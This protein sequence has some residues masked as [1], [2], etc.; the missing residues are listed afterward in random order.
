MSGTA[1][2]PSSPPTARIDRKSRLQMVWLIPIVAVGIALFL[3]YR[4]Y[5]SRGPTILLTFTTAD[6]LQAGQTKVKHKA[7][8]LGTV[9]GIR[10]S[11]DMSHVEVSVEMQHAAD[12]LLTERARFWVV[13]PRL[14]VG[15]VSG[16]DTLLSGAY[17]SIDP[18]EGGG[19]RQIRFTGLEEPPA[20][21]SDEPGTTYV[22]NTARIGSLSSGSPVFF[23]DI[24]VGEVLGYDL[25]PN[26]D[27]VAIKVFVRAPYN[28]FV[29]SA[30]RFWN[31][32]G[33][34]VDLGTQGVRVQME[35]LLAVIAGGVAFDTPGLHADDKPI[36]ANT[37]FPLFR[38]QT[39]A[40]ESGYSVNARLMARFEGSVR[41]LAPGA[42]VEMFGIRVG[43][44]SSVRLEAD[45]AK[46][47]LFVE[48][49]F[50]IQ[51]DRLP[52]TDRL[53][54]DGNEIDVARALVA[55]G[56]RVQ[57]ATGNFLTGSK[58][59]SLE[60]MPDAPPAEVKQEGNIIVLP[61]APGGLDNI[62]ASVGQILD[63]VNRLPL[64]Q[65]VANLNTAIAGVAGMTNGPEIKSALQSMA[66]AMASANDALKHIDSGLGP[67]MSKLPQ[68]AQGLQT[69]VDRASRL[70]ATMDA[71]YGDNSEFR[72]NLI[73]LLSQA[74]ETARSVRLLAD[75][76]DQ[77]PEALVRG[78]SGRSGD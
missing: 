19:A 62:A 18:G 2:P 70:L 10:L 53:L 44:V 67:T 20:V 59:V 36:A 69:T 13:R 71:G 51:R 15:G 46:R 6:G 42:A 30:T 27:A 14:G 56:L 47:D 63:K 54:H 41:G 5:T 25:S 21:R 35:S 23:H 26:G 64:D 34:S 17:I 32:S 3:G 22:L 24:Q 39:Q 33:L 28:R 77:H 78:R 73:R 52:G 38:D 57:L 8:D 4:A 55:R 75:F 43:S 7:V 61:S 68:I 1:H 48:V 74:S 50:D 45:T 72:R 11:D 60:F 31:A 12:P 37:A 58:I 65:V 40:T 9:R 16:L 66:Q 29:T 76:L 49:G